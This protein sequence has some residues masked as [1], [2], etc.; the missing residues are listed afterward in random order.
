MPKLGPAIYHG[1]GGLQLGCWQPIIAGMDDADND[2]DGLA[3]GMPEHRRDRERR[4]AN[5]K[6]KLRTGWKGLVADFLELLGSG[7]VPDSP[8]SDT[9]SH[10]AG[11]LEWHHFQDHDFGGSGDHHRF[12]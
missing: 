11:G 4:A 5:R 2:A 12:D 6:A 3:E 7:P 10:H 8:H 9:G 1:S